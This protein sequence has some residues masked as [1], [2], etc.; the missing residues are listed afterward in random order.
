MYKVK[1]YYLY[2]E[3]KEELGQY[4]EAIECLNNIHNQHI[5]SKTT[6]MENYFTKSYLNLGRLFY[7]LGNLA[8]S[9]T[10]LDRF[11]KKAKNSDGKEMLDLA[12]VNFGMVKANQLLDSHIKKMTTSTYKEFLS[13]KLKYFN[14]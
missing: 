1:G 10:N 4:R 8:E 12:R 2:G 7:K 11:F 5:D 3:T 13:S 14:D 6:E 9:S